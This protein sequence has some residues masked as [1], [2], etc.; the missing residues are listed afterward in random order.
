MKIAIHE[1]PNP[2]SDLKPIR[3]IVK[4]LPHFGERPIHHS[5][6]WRWIMKGIGET[7]LKYKRVGRRICTSLEY[8]DEFFDALAREDE[9]RIARHQAYLDTHPKPSTKQREREIGDAERTL[10]DEGMLNQSLEGIE[11]LLDSNGRLLS[12]DKV[13]RVLGSL[14]RFLESYRDSPGLNLLSG[15]GRLV[16]DDFENADGAPRFESTLVRA[17]ADKKFWNVFLEKLCEFGSLLPS[18]QRNELSEQI[19]SVTRDRDELIYV[20]EQLEDDTSAWY[21]LE[22]FVE[23]LTTLKLG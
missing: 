6:V 19:C 16:T 5:T 9:E 2:R 17:K 7:R 18:N 22:L 23:D 3:E 11:Y 8:I 12:K 1:S 10:E 15:L 14:A 21:F 13:I 20:H 4:Q